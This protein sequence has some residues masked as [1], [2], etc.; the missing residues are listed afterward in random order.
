MPTVQ[1]ERLVAST[2]F[3]LAVVTDGFLHREYDNMIEMVPKPQCPCTCVTLPINLVCIL[4][5]GPTD[6]QTLI[7]IYQL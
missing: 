6:H 1:D 3:A 5:Q 2:N 4:E 7:I